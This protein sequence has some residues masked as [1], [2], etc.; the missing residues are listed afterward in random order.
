MVEILRV[1]GIFGTRSPDLN[2][3]NFLGSILLELRVV[4]DQVISKL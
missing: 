1:G 3:V 4:C 2:T